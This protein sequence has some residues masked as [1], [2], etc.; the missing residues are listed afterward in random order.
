MFW[1]Q[2]RLCDGDTEEEVIAGY[3]DRTGG[4]DFGSDWADLLAEREKARKEGRGLADGTKRWQEKVRLEEM[5][6][7][8]GMV[9]GEKESWEWGSRGWG[10]EDGGD[11]GG[12]DEREGGWVWE[13]SWGYGL[14]RRAGKKQRGGRCGD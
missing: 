10:G 12:D 4:R 8:M 5:L 9:V 11:V 6:R 14:M 7:E 1:A 13:R 2:V 3:K